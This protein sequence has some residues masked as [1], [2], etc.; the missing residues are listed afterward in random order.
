MHATSVTKI[1][2]FTRSVLKTP[3]FRLVPVPKTPLFD[4]CPCLRPLFWVVPV[5]KTPTPFWV[6]PVPKTPPPLFGCAA[7][8][9]HQYILRVPPPGLWI[10]PPRYPP[11]PLVNM[12]K[13]APSR[14]LQINAI[15]CWFLDT[16]NI[17]A[18]QFRWFRWISD[19]C[20]EQ[21]SYIYCKTDTLLLCFVSNFQLF[22]CIWRTTHEDPSPSGL[23]VASVS[24]FI[25]ELEMT[26]HPEL[27]K[28]QSSVLL[29]NTY[30]DL[31]F[32]HRWCTNVVW[33]YGSGQQSPWSRVRIRSMSWT[34]VINHQSFPD[35]KLAKFSRLMS[36][37]VT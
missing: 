18:I 2:F 11:L 7:A 36:T 32:S 27:Q 10:P 16:K 3:L 17:V 34:L 22:E 28:C 26:T 30:Q 19:T 14:S 4:S 31:I 6:V 13:S 21:C 25:I 12:K 35:D 9:P 23:F 33:K 1:V 5:P 8:H 15:L 37:D 24:R 29:A 20:T